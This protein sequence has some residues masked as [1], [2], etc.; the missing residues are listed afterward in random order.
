MVYLLPFF[1]RQIYDIYDGNKLQYFV[2]LSSSHLCQNKTCYARPPRQARPAKPT[3]Q[4][5][6][7]RQLQINNQSLLMENL[8]FNKH[9]VKPMGC[10]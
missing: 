6:P 2:V 9:S 3:R 1:H 5:R 10:T 8:N 4:A 7:A